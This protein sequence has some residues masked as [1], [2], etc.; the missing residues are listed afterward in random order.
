MLRWSREGKWLPLRAG[1]RTQLPFICSLFI[2][3]DMLEKRGG[4]SA[5]KEKKTQRIFCGPMSKYFIKKKGLQHWKS[6]R[7]PS[8]TSLPQTQVCTGSLGDGGRR[9]HHVHYY[10]ETVEYS[11]R[12]QQVR[13]KPPAQESHD[14]TEALSSH[15]SRAAENYL[16]ALGRIKRQAKHRAHRWYVMNIAS[17]LTSSPPEF[18]VFV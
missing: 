14:L 3:K 13:F 8:P 10:T 12:V 7:R 15:L 18:F 11:S 1:L 16:L 2:L 17:L 9:G 5:L 6:R 4:N